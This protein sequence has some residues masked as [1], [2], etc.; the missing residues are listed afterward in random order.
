MKRYLLILVTILLMASCSGDTTLTPPEPLGDPEWRELN[1]IPVTGDLRA[2]WGS[3]PNDIFAAGWN[4]ADVIHFNGR[5]WS[6]QMS[7]QY[8]GFLDLWGSSS[9]DVYAAGT[10]IARYDGTEWTTVYSAPNLRLNGVWGSSASDVYFAGA[11][12][13]LLHWDGA[14]FEP[15]DMGTISDL[16]DVWGSGPDDV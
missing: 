5:E 16:R 14:A 8:S 3:G 1:R 6:L 10:M 15:I 2:V 11:R 9:A 13:L 4:D 7:S 12:G